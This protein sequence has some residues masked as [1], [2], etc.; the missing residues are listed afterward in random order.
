MAVTVATFREWGRI[1]EGEQNQ[2]LQLCLDAAQ[3][4]LE[5][6]GVPD[7]ADGSLYEVMVYRLALDIYEHRT[8]TDTDGG[9]EALY[10]VQQGVNLLHY[11]GE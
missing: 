6:Q 9:T 2:V 11:G 10:G 4:N 3:E 7:D 1:D 8:A 5:G